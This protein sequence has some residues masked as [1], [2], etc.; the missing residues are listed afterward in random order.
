MMISGFL[1]KRVSIKKELEKSFRC[2][3]IPYLLFNAVL[4]IISLFFYSFQWMDIIDILTGNQERLIWNC[5]Y[6]MWYLIS[7]LIM[8]IISS[9]CKEEWYLWV[10]LGFFVV[11]VFVGKIAPYEY[12][13]FQ[14]CTTI[15]CYPFFLMGIILKKYNAFELPNKI[16]PIIRYLLILF[17]LCVLVYLMKFNGFANIFRCVTG[18]SILLYYL[19]CVSFSCLILYIF[20]KLFTKESTI[21]LTI[22]SGTVLILGLHRM[23]LLGIIHT[24]PKNTFTAIIVSFIVMLICYPLIVLAKKYFPVLLGSRGVSNKKSN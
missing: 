20:S 7:I 2:I 22:S 17:I 19:I 14:L 9:L 8:R 12:D 3:V 13:Y 1:Y 21:I 6:P 24:L 23:F 5:F 4:L 18:N 11:G 16:K 10:M 15:M